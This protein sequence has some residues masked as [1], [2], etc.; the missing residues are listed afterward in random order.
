MN[1][2][3]I[4][5]VMNKPLSR[6][7]LESGIPARFSYVGLD[8]APRVIPI[9]YVWDGSE[10]LCWTT[11]RSAKVAALRRNPK[12]AITID[13]ERFPPNVLLLRGEASVEVVDGCPDGYVE[14][15]RRMVPPDQ[16]ADWAAG[17]RSLYRQMAAITIEL[18][19]AKLLDFESTLPKAVEDLVREYQQAHPQG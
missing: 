11:P 3:D 10:I 17:V 14:A 12:V 1:T 7:L 16:F 4:G 15:G 2:Q 18:T 19:W 9:G 5:D 8:G 6:Q 13:T